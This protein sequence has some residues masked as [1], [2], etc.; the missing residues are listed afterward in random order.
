MAQKG[1][2]GRT[3]KLQTNQPYI[4]D[5]KNNGENNKGEN[6]HPSRKQQLN[7]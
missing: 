2:K 7:F 1:T 6:Y 5:K 3:R 4:C